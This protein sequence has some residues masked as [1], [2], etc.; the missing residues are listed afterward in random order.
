[1]PMQVAEV[2][3]ALKS[4]TPVL[5]LLLLL[6]HHLPCRSNAALARPS[7]VSRQGGRGQATRAEAEAAAAA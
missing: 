1:M 5:L 7:P 2:A 3:A 6:L 4:T